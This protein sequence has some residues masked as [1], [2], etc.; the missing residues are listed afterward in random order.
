MGFS[1][2]PTT[3]RVGDG[4]VS[5]RPAEAA[6]EAVFAGLGWDTL[7]YGLRDVDTGTALVARLTLFL[8]SK[9]D[10]VAKRRQRWNDEAALLV[11]S[12]GCDGGVAVVK[13]RKVLAALAWQHFANT[14]VVFA[15]YDTAA[16][17]LWVADLNALL[18]CLRSPAAEAFM[19]DAGKRHQKLAWRLPLELLRQYQV[20][21][22]GAAAVTAER[23]AS[24]LEELRQ[25]VGS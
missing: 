19:L 14:P 17:E 25:A 9:P 16:D 3:Q 2:L 22:A 1:D 10:F 20:A 23:R 5:G 11:E 8:A 18:A 24:D 7:P 21:D 12:Q 6:T 13:A 4:S 15:V